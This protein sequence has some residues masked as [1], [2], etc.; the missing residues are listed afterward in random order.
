MQAFAV[1]DLGFGD[2]G[3]GTIVDYLA[4]KYNATLVVRYNGGAQA[5][6]NVITPEG[7][8]HAFSQFGS[9]TF[10][11]AATYLSRFMVVSPPAFNKEAIQLPSAEVFVDS[12]ALVTTPYHQA[13][14]RL[15]EAGRGAFAH[16]TC[17]LGVGETVRDALE[18]GLDAL[19][20]QD[21]TDQIRVRRKLKATRDRL[22]AK[23]RGLPLL[24][25]RDK[26]ILFGDDDSILE[27]YLEQCSSFTGKIEITSIEVLDAAL[28]SGTVIFEGA[29]GVLLDEWYG[30]HPYTTWSTTTLANVSKLLQECG[31]PHHPLERIGVTR[32]YMTR[33][34]PGP[35][36]TEDPFLDL[37]DIHNDSLGM[38]GRFRVGWT[39]LVM[40]RYATKLCPVDW[41]AVTSADRI[42]LGWKIAKS[43]LF[44]EGEVPEMF[45]GTNSITGVR[46]K[47]DV[48]DL[49]YQ[50]H[51]T[52]AL[53]HCAPQYT[54]VNERELV[55]LLENELDIPVRLLSYG[56]TAADKQERVPT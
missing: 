42:G 18:A 54:T 16:G 30:F 17:G 7:R 45:E 35:F 31:C 8:H 12:Q 15:A 11:G 44:S 48:T 26:D 43:Y 38:Q 36:I 39:D 37:P 6:H 51:I 24:S 34:G 25:A 50:E 52:E 4:R 33:H 41:L 20:V 23:W 40:L 1:V 56:P 3:K 21:L 49:N 46:I 10:A 9:G 14:N 28:R 13:S 32:S 19:R 2:S 47:T 53:R 29:Q 27:W 55:V 22:Q 5:S